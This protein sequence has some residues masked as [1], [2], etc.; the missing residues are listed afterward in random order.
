MIRLL[1]IIFSFL[2]LVVV[3]PVF[4]IVYVLGLFD[5]GSPLFWQERV[6]KHMKPFVLLK[7]RTMHTSTASVATH[8]ASQS[9]VTRFGSFLRKSKVDE[10]PQLWNVLKGE[11][12]LVGPRPNLFSQEELIAER[13]ALKVYDVR[14][15]IT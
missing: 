1:D 13:S 9:S 7:F 14:P 6:G 10:L 3:S 11:M 8:L 4:L 5:T 12:S 15:V 2:G